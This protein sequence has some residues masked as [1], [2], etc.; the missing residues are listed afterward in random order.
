MLV[1]NRWGDVYICHGQQFKI[2][3]KSVKCV[4]FIEWISPIL[5]S[6]TVGLVNGSA[7]KLSIIVEKTWHCVMVV[8]TDK[9][10]RA[11]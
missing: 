6:S 10:F 11:K 8:F 4:K 3:N 7:G 2:Q 1:Q 9:T 5:T